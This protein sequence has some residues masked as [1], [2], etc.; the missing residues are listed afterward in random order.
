MTERHDT[1]NQAREH[2]FKMHHFDTAGGMHSLT[3]KKDQ[4]KI[5]VTDEDESS[6]FEMG[7]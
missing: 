4:I 5:E 6:E 1:L 2:A 7:D 3:M